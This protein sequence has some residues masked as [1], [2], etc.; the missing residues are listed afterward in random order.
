MILAENR[1]HRLQLASDLE[2][3]GYTV[4]RTG[5]VDE[6]LGLLDQ[7]HNVS[8]VLWD[9][10]AHGHSGMA[11]LA[12]AK[13]RHPGLTLLGISGLENWL[14]HERRHVRRRHWLSEIVRIAVEKK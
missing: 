12:E 4:L 14:S 8:V 7:G 3:I 5:T 2:Q 9:L 10:M 11:R 13:S 6:A 1:A